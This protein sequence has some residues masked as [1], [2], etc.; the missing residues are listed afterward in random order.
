MLFS[1]FTPSTSR[2]TLMK[3][4]GTDGASPHADMFAGKLREP[5]PVWVATSSESAPLSPMEQPCDAGLPGEPSKICANRNTPP[6]EYVVGNVNAYGTVCPTTAV[7][8]VWVGRP[9]MR[10]TSVV[11]ALLFRVYCWLPAVVVASVIVKLE[12]AG[13]RLLIV[14]MLVPRFCES[15]K[16]SSNVWPF[17]MN[18]APCTSVGDVF[19]FQIFRFGSTGPVGLL[20][21]PATT[22]A[23]TTPTGAEAPAKMKVPLKT[24]V[25]SEAPPCAVRLCAT[26]LAS[27]TRWLP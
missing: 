25:P 9:L 8:A 22:A 21:G 2:N 14:A 19:P 12:P 10:M 4:I 26:T 5:E 18:C 1:E 11:N 6:I 16:N 20:T 24:P 23:V 7:S 3:R 27:P 13:T 17:R 15:R